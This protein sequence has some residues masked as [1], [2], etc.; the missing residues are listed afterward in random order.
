MSVFR[1]V[2][3]SLA[4]ELDSLG[5]L[6]AFPASADTVRAVRRAY[7]RGVLMRR[8]S[9]TPGHERLGQWTIRFLSRSTYAYLF[10]EIFVRQVYAFPPSTPHPRIIDCGSNIGLSVIY[11]SLMYP[12][13]EIV[14]FE[15]FDPAFECLQ[16]N[17]HDNHLPRVQLNNLAVGKHTGDTALYFDE[18]DLGSLRVS[19]L[20]ERLPGRAQRTRVVRLSDYISTPIDLLKLDVE[21]AETD[22]IHDL[23]ETG[24]SR[25]IQRMI[26][27]Y[28]HHIVR[29]VDRLSHLLEMLEGAGFGYQ[30]AA[31]TGTPVQ[32]AEYQ[33]VQIYAYRHASMQERKNGLSEDVGR[34]EANSG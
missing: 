6:R 11:F 10:R 21:G 9:P 30:I 14:A 17:V 7:I 34:L 28:H 13:A 19:T 27:E 5:R 20:S 24:K 15:P 12:D 31:T 22:V 32:E 29:D 3:R 8:P 25:F 23:V 16:H 33:D 26:V 1:R 2:L 4:R 18:Q